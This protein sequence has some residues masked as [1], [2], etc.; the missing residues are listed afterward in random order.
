MEEHQE[1]NE[2]LDRPI[3]TQHNP[4]SRIMVQR[5]TSTGFQSV[6]DA[7][8][9][10][11]LLTTTE[12]GLISKLS[13]VLEAHLGILQANASAVMII[14]PPL[15]P[16]PGLISQE[17]EATVRSKDITN[18][19]LM[20][21]GRIE[22]LELTELVNSMRDEKGGLI[23]IHKLRFSIG[24]TAAVSVKYSSFDERRPEA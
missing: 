3:E 21:Q 1:N 9:Y 10:L 16:E 23:V 11:V 5:G 17:V 15:L 18:R 14:A 24:A 19:Q 20:G 4:H 13:A 12:T 22:V 6:R 8:V 2:Y 7:A